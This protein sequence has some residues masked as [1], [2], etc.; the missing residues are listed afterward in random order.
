MWKQAFQ[1]A[2]VYI[3]TIVG[4]G[5]A[6]GREIIE[7]FTKYGTA[8]FVGIGIAGWLFIA[9]GTKIMHLA[10]HTEAKTYE[11]LTTVL[12]GEKL[13]IAINMVLFIML[14]GVTSVMLSGAGALFEEQLHLPFH[15]GVIA[16][17]VC[18]LL[19]MRKGMSGLVTANVFIVPIM[20][21]F[22]MVIACTSFFS[23]VQPSLFVKEDFIRNISW[24]WSPFT[25]VAFNLTLAQ[26]VLVPL[27]WEASDRRS[28]TWGGIIGGM[29]LAFILFNSQYALYV[30]P[31]AQTF[32]IPVAFIVEKLGTPLHL[33]FLAVVYGEIFS[34][35]IGN[36]F[37]LTATIKKVL[38]LPSLIVMLIILLGAYLISLVGY[39]SLL[40][41]IYPLFGSIGLLFMVI[42]ARRKTVTS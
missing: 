23:V 19:V 2:A 31:Q 14:F 40:H 30:H 4:A 33:L 34:T 39:S 35:L 5:F 7:F 1:I 9:L 37:G 20:I 22:S 3:G 42:L 28:I 13:S 24:L 21:L 17:I 12:F 6:T 26:A 25:Y 10:R 15:V 16:T 32:N 29:G 27:G 8:G 38:A 41:Y 11:E 18:C 36:L